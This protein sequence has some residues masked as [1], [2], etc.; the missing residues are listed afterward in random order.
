MYVNSLRL[1]DWKRYSCKNTPY[2]KCNICW[3]MT[4][5]YQIYKETVD[6]QR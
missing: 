2:K 3:I 5:H 1:Y 6:I 4:I